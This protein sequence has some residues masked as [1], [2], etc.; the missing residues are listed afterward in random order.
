[1]TALLSQSKNES[2]KVAF[3][4]SDCR[5]MEIEVLPPDVNA[6]FWDFSIE[7]REEQ[8]SAIRFGLGAVK[9]VGQGSG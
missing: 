2:E 4:I 7:D 9:N 1:M 8:P 5:S 3:Y 6:S